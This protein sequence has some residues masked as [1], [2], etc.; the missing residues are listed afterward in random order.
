[1][2]NEI[3]KNSNQVTEFSSAEIELIKQ[4]ICRGASDSELKLFL[5]ACKRTGLDPFLKQIYSVSGKNG[6][7]TLVSI[8]GLRLTADRTGCYCPG[9]E[10][11]YSYDA[12]GKLISATA[13]IKKKTSDGIWHEVGASALLTEYTK[14]NLWNSM[15]HVM[16][17]KVAESICL[18]KSFPADLASLYIEEETYQSQIQEDATSKTK[19]SIVSEEQA[20]E[21]A[22]IYNDSPQE[23]KDKILPWL[24]SNK[25]TSTFV[26]LPA[27]FYAR[28]K[29]EM[30]DCSQIKEVQVDKAVVEEVNT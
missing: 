16:L 23:C 9:K 24:N 25:L 3:Q 17:S 5:Y 26:G 6:R 4:S 2:S 22:E 27:K 11:S 14:G 13:Y 1:M 20:F 18:R 15:P 8:D 28:F 19:L 29:K 12:N 7:M 30:S 10:T 21:L